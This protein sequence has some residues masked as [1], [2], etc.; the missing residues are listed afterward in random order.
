MIWL[1]VLIPIGVVAVFGLVIGLVLNRRK[2]IRMRKRNLTINGK[3]QYLDL[4]EAVEEITNHS[5]EELNVNEQLGSIK[6]I[7]SKFDI[8]ELSEFYH[9]LI[10]ARG[11]YHWIRSEK[12][13]GIEEDLLKARKD[14][15]SIIDHP[16][17]LLDPHS[18]VRLQGMIEHVELDLKILREKR[19]GRS[20]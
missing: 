9:S 8:P 20:L 6:E 16:Q 12:A 14:M 1:Y 11:A 18:R 4:E 17:I 2:C 7:F 5:D 15:L 3:K 19:K 13:E 10:W